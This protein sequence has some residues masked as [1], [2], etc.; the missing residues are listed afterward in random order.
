[1]R[2]T[3]EL[4]DDVSQRIDVLVER[5][6]LTRDQIVEDALTQGRSLAWQEKWVQGV[7]AGIDEADKGQFAHPDEIAAVLNRFDGI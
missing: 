5:T 4:S 1:M 6:G 3:F 7:R 2:S